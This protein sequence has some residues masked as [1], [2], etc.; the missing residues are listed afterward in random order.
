[1]GVGLVLSLNM[2]QGGGLIPAARS[3]MADTACIIGLMQRCTGVIVLE[4][5]DPNDSY[6]SH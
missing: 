5:T 3:Q 1:M 4:N 6:H 2:G